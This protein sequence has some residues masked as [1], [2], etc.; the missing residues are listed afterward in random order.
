MGASVK[1]DRLRFRT[2]PRTDVTFPGDP[3]DSISESE[4]ENLPDEVKAGRTYRDVEV[5]WG[6]AAWLRPRRQRQRRPPPDE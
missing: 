4:R 6:A 1:A 5:R 2:V 3:A